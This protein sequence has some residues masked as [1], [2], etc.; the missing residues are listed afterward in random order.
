M[1][2]FLTTDFAEDV[3]RAKCSEPGLL[4]FFL[5]D[6]FHSETTDLSE[7][8]TP[9]QE[10]ELVRSCG[11]AGLFFGRFKEISECEPLQS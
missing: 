6:V 7:K 3:K 11:E 8:A 1:V 2:P 9:T 4:F 10:Q 5:L